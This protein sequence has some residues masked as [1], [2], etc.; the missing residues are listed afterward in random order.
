MHSTCFFTSHVCAHF[1]G[2]LLF[3]ARLRSMVVG[4]CH[5]HYVSHRLFSSHSIS[6]NFP[7]NTNVLMCQAKKNW[8]REKRSRGGEKRLPQAGNIL[9]FVYLL[10]VCELL[11]QFQLWKEEKNTKIWRYLCT[12]LF[13]SQYSN[14][15]ISMP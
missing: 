14:A 13:T 4:W 6:I 10:L 2:L 5:L 11:S 3:L 7:S 15:N 8:D 1:V 9:W 12:F